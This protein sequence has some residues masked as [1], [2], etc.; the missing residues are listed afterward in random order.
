MNGEYVRCYKSEQQQNKEDMHTH[1]QR[2]TTNM[3]KDKSALVNTYTKSSQF[4]EGSAAATGQRKTKSMR[5][6]I[7]KRIAAS[8]ISREVEKI[9]LHAK[10]SVR[11]FY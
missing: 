2:P 3:F 10:K 1:K 6:N 7:K 11:T 8:S 9:K 5:N 4:F